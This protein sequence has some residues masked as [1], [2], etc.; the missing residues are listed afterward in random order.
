MLRQEHKFFIKSEDVYLIVNILKPLMYLDKN[1]EHENPYTITST[2][3]DNFDDTDLFDK[4]NGIRFR[5]KYRLRFY[6]NNNQIGNFEVKRKNEYSVEKTAIS[7]NVDEQSRLLNGD[8]SILLK[9]KR[10]EYISH[11]MTYKHYKPKTVVRYERIAFTL[12][13][14]NIRITLD[15]NLRSLGFY[16][17]HIET[18]HKAGKLLMPIGYEILELKFLDCIPDYLQKI[19]S[20]Y[21]LSRA[22]IGKYILARFYNNTELN[23]DN[24]VLPF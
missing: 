22:S 21:S 1:C 7:L 18:S 6:N 16:S 24:P 13:F 10:F 14:N 12:P 15:L 19:I 23:N 17:P 2:Y 8:Y 20:N 5:E 9:D 11:R 3:F 4:L